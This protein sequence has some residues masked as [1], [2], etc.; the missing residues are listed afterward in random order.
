MTLSSIEYPQEGRP[1]PPLSENPRIYR[2]QE[3]IRLYRGDFTVLDPLAAGDSQQLRF[4][5]IDG[6]AQ[7]RINVNAF[8]QMCKVWRDFM[9]GNPP[10]LD[11]EDASDELMQRL[12]DVSHSFLAASKSV[13]V[14]CVRYGAGVYVIR[15]P[16]IIESLDPRFWFPVTSPYDLNDI[17]GH[18]IAYPY[19]TNQ[20]R[21]N[22]YQTPKGTSRTGQGTAP[23]HVRMYRF[24]VEGERWMCEAGT[25]KYEGTSLGA[26][27]ERWQT[28]PCGSPPLVPV[29]LEGDD[30]YGESSFDDIRQHVAEINRR[31]TQLSEAL[32]KHANPHLAVEES[33]RVT[34]ESGRVALSDEGSIISYAEGGKPPSYVTWEPDFTQH[35]ES[36]ARA[37]KRIL[38]LNA[39]SAIL[40]DP[41]GEDLDLVAP[42]G[43]ALR[44]MAI[45][46]VQRIFQYRSVFE[47]AMGQA[48]AGALSDA[49]TIDP[50]MVIVNWPPPLD[51]TGAEDASELVG[52]VEGGI[53]PRE[54]AIRQVNRVTTQE[55]TRLAEEADERDQQNNRPQDGQ[56]PGGVREDA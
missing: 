27:T 5:S 2:A 53:V 8:R 45:V 46:T 15:Q 47:P 36:I 19:V 18:I 48:V 32:D 25:F 7:R 16:G 55:A 34:D 43:T 40:V 29:V 11:Y 37:E 52:L 22:S 49:F 51:D 38:A 35:N 14:N 30:I 26:M 21:G 12:E 39:V 23:D 54:R 17:Q 56:L 20:D 4:R 6:Q 44:R 3:N 10:V 33:T 50:R 24:R 13:T 28:M 1:W 31:E 41:A 9:F 42:S